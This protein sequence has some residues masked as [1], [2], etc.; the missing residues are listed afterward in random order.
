MKKTDRADYLR[1]LSKV[2]SRCSKDDKAV[3]LLVVQVE[4]LD[5]VEGA[6]GYEKSHKLLDRKSTRLNSSH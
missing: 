4:Q 1:D 3:G 5:K 2:I 6:F